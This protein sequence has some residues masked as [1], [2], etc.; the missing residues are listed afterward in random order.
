MDEQ[1]L[2]NGLIGT[3]RELNM[4]VRTLPEERLQLGR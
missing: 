4:K 1:S 3:Y 2:F